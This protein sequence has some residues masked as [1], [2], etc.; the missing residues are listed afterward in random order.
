MALYKIRWRRGA[1]KAVKKI[2]RKFIPKILKAIEDLA[3]NPMP[4]NHK[5]MVG[6]FH[7][8][9]IRVGEYRVVYEVIDDELI[10]EVVR[11]GHRKDVYRK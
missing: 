9:R 11:L 2:D 1:V 5:K 10:I 3:E 8:Y 7:S 6:T 4:V